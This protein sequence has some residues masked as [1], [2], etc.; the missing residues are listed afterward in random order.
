[1]LWKAIRQPAWTNIQAAN[2]LTHENRL[3]L[4]SYTA[5]VEDVNKCISLTCLLL[6]ESRC[7]GRSLFWLVFFR[8]RLPFEAV[9]VRAGPRG[10]APLPTSMATTL[11]GARWDILWFV[12]LV[13]HGDRLQCALWHQEGLPAHSRAGCGRIG[14]HRAGIFLMDELFLHKLG[15]AG[16]RGGLRNRKTLL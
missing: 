6:N 10:C 4:D 5:A 1:M 12:L 15:L 14:A 11:E 2:S 9:C 13:F 7:R 3:L 8:V 16:E